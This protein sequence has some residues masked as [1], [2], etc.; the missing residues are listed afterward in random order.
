MKRSSGVTVS[1]KL[2]VSAVAFGVLAIAIL[3]GTFA[4]YG[5]FL[6]GVSIVGPVAGNMLGAAEPVSAT[7]IS[8]LWLGTAFVWADWAGLA[9]MVL[10]IFLIALPS[11]PSKGKAANR[12]E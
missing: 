2:V 7:A 6:H 11:S 9:L 5:M 4:A 8:A 3:V 12:T 10:T 1:T